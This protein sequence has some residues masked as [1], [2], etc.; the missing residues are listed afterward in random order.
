MIS[1]KTSKALWMP[2]LNLNQQN[3]KIPKNARTATRRQHRSHQRS[4]ALLPGT[5]PASAIQGNPLSENH[6]PETP[7]EN[8]WPKGT[9]V[10]TQNPCKLRFHADD[11]SGTWLGAFVKQSSSFAVEGEEHAF[12]PEIQSHTY[13]H[14]YIHAYIHTRLHTYIP[15][16]L[17]TCIH[18]YTHAYIHTYIHTYVHTHTHTLRTFCIS[19]CM[20]ARPSAL[21]NSC[22]T[23]SPKDF[24]D[25]SPAIGRP[26]F[27]GRCSPVFKGVRFRG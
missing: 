10:A 15:A 1:K 13:I 20:N 16:Y 17:H 8:L 9:I 19:P 21:L 22:E 7:H 23:K 11:T 27:E 2:G 26:S 24:G 5:S 3:P 25:A 14:T 12:N 18:T 4:Q 6:E